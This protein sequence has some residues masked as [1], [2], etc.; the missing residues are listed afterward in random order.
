M[1]KSQC[2][3]SPIKTDKQKMARTLTYVA[4]YEGTLL[5]WNSDVGLFP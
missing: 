2:E 1:I 5:S 3:A 4:L